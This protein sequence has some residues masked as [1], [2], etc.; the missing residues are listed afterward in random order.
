MALSSLGRATTQA[1]QGQRSAKAA[2][3]TAQQ[4]LHLLTQLQTAQS[5][6]IT[7]CFGELAIR[8]RVGLCGVA[9]CGVVW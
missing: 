8:V 6:C 3:E 2:G 1:V 4:L 9:W 5:K 7:W